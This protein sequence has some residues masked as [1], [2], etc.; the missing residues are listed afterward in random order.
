MSG[1][2]WEYSHYKIKDMLDEI[3]MDGGLILKAPKLANI[4]RQLATLL[5]NTTYE[6]DYHFSGDTEITNWKAFE[7]E[8]V[9]RLGK[10][11]KEKLKLKVY[12]VKKCK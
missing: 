6:L 2:H 3:G 4:Y 9:E 1:G 12:E 8:F 11:I 7:A 5:E 10:I